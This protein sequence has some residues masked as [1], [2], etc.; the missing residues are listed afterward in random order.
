M[1]CGERVGEWILS[2]LGVGWVRG[3]KREGGK[4]RRE[5]GR[6][7]FCCPAPFLPTL[8]HLGQDDIS[9]FACLGLVARRKSND[10]PAGRACLLWPDDVTARSRGTPAP[11]VN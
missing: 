2:V 1:F 4:L 10:A 11:G 5:Q 6:T 3:M 7:V 9:F 8:V